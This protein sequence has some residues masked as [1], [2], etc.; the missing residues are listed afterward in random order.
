[1]QYT[2]NYNSIFSPGYVVKLSYLFIFNV[3]E[4]TC[5]GLERYKVLPK[6]D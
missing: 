1:M 2:I 6:I 4:L 3:H 5:K